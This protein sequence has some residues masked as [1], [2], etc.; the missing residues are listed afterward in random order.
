MVILVMNFDYKTLEKFDKIY[1][2]VSGGFD[3]TYLYD[4][5]K[6]LYPLTCIP[7]NC[8]NPYEKGETLDIISNDPKFIEVRPYYKLNYGDVLKE[9]FMKLPEAR[10]KKKMGVYDKKIFPCCYWIKHKD[11]KKDPRF[12]EPNTVV[13]SGIKAGDGMQ[14]GLWL[15]KLRKE[16][17]WY[18]RHKEGQ[19]Y[20]YP[21]RDFTKR[22]FPDIVNRRLLKKYPNLAHSGC[23][24]CPIL[25]L[26]NLRKGNEKRYDASIKYAKKLG[27]L[28]YKA[29]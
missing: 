8:Y 22:D 7:V 20:C 15:A 11:F 12:K 9:A 19:L 21:F 28:D 6:K 10:K 16:K 27:V 3:S 24:L 29:F 14:R 25:I 23:Y 4:K 13:I 5:I 26:Y 17:R 18:H 2:L 1:V